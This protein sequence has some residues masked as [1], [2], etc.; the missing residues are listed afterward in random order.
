MSALYVL[1]AASLAV[2][3]AFLAGFVWAVRSGQFDDTQ[4]PPLRLL[5]DENR[6]PGPME[7]KRKQST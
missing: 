4:T 5:G 3:V 1:L 7:K 6:K 2:A